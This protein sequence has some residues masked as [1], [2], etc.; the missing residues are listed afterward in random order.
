MFLLRLRM[1]RLSLSI[2][3]LDRRLGK[4]Y[5]KQHE[6]TTFTPITR[7]SCDDS[8]QTKKSLRPRPDQSRKIPINQNDDSYER[9]K[10]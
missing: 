10:K 7:A 2:L 1:E 5:V 6:P 4:N 9:V 3:T 8:G